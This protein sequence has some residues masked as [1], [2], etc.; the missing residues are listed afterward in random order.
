[1]FIYRA[2]LHLQVRMALLHSIPSEAQAMAMSPCGELPRT[3]GTLCLGSVNAAHFGEG[4][5]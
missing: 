2:G 1:M 3:P 4:N 5:T